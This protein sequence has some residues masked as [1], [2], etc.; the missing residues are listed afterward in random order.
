M[1][2]YAR[3]KSDEQKVYQQRMRAVRET[4]GKDE[5]APNGMPR[6]AS[7]YCKQQGAVL[8]YG[9]SGQRCFALLTG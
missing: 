3:T 8:K 1:R 5:L 9:A 6:I 4:L 2:G 7:E